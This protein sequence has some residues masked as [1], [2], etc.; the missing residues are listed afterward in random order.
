M[1]GFGTFQE[2]CLDFSDYFDH[3]RAIRA[4]IGDCPAEK[5]R[6]IL[7]D[8]YSF[9]EHFD[10]YMTD[11]YCYSNTVI[12]LILSSRGQHEKLKVFY[13]VIRERISQLGSTKP[14]EYALLIGCLNNDDETAEYIIREQLYY[15]DFHKD[16]YF[17]EPFYFLMIT[18][19][20]E[21]IPAAMERLR[22]CP[23]A[24]G[25][26]EIDFGQ[27]TDTV[28]SAAYFGDNKFLRAWF[29]G[30][31]QIDKALILRLYPYPEAIEFIIR[32]FY[33]KFGFDKPVGIYEFIKGCLNA[34]EILDLAYDIKVRYGEECFHQFAEDMRPMEKAHIIHGDTLWRYT[35]PTPQANTSST[36]LFLREFLDEK[37]TVVMQDNA[38]FPLLFEAKRLLEGHSITYDMTNYSDNYFIWNISTSEWTD[39]LKTCDFIFPESGYVDML[40]PILQKNSKALTRI[41][42]KKGIINKDNYK[43]L[44]ECLVS[45][46]L[47]NV[48]AVINHSKI[49]N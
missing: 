47:L 30:G 31:Y 19:K 10:V 9:D 27:H 42:I 4:A 1:L 20:Y 26:S 21:L 2:K 6:E 34:D 23:K 48:L 49:V 41:L 28:A 5:F 17:I 29:E 14:I 18:G 36:V 11:C 40:Y 12:K 38:A 24:S 45:E 43:E 3:D 7:R 35:M 16:I 33:D 25:V 8:L 32:E 15:L 13:E 39:L 37:V 44:L 22:S 46:K